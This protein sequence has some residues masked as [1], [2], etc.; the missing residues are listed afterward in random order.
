MLKEQ[1]PEQISRQAILNLRIITMQ[2]E[3][4]FEQLMLQY[5]QLKNGA[6]D[7]KRMIENED[8]DNAIT[9]LNMREEI[10]R[11]CKCMR[12]YLELT[13][14]QTKELDAILEELKTLEMSNIHLLSKNIETA[15]QELRKSHQNEK[16]INAYGYNESQKGSIVNVEE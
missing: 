8:F 2:D 14:V 9:M 4:Q 15:R 10:F 1:F 12:K 7:I 5:N 6:A 11:N 13:P 16:F 3:K